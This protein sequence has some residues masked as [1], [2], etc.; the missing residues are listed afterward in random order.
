[1]AR[2]K[3]IIKATTYD[4]RGRMIA[5]AFNS[6]S[7]THPMMSEI[8]C[9]CDLPDKE[10]LHAEVACII[11]SRGKKIH[12]IFVERYDQN[13][14]PKNAAPCKI[15]QRAIQLAEIKEVTYTVG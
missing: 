4:K 11:K 8:G 12:K 7:K 15:C 3:Y 2:R 14:N 10:Y 1:M 13:G 6:Y 9:D 5:S